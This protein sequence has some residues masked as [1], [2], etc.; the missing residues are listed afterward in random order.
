MK[1]YN[2]EMSAQDNLADAGEQ[3]DTP[4]FDKSKFGKRNS[5]DASGFQ[6]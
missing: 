5:I 6:F 2:V 4:L 3:D 1:L